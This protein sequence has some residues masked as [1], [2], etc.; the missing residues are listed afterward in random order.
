MT[1]KRFENVLKETATIDVNFTTFLVSI[2][3][4]SRVKNA[5][6]AQTWMMAS[7]ASID[8]NTIASLLLL[9]VNKLLVSVA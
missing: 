1:L 4:D 6:G 9:L 7:V 8:I 2:R 3:A 5:A